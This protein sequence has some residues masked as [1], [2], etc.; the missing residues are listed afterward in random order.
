MIRGERTGVMHMTDT[1]EPGGAERVAVNIVNLLPRESYKPY[2]CTTRRDG[3]LDELVK[4]DV[5]RLRLRRRNRID[6]RALGELASYLRQENIEIVHAH[7][8][9]LFVA[10]AVSV[11][12]PYPVVIWH[13]H[14]GRYALKERSVLLYRLA[15]RR[16]GGVIAVNHPLTVWAEKRLLIPPARVWYIPNFVVPSTAD[17]N[18]NIELPGVAGKRIVCVANLR[19]QKDHATLIQAMRRVVET[20]PAA[21]LLLVG[22]TNDAKCVGELRQLIDDSNLH[23]NVTLLGQRR[24]VADVLARCDIGVLSSLSEGLPLA[25]I[26]YGIA[27]LATVATAIGQ[28]AE[29]LDEGRSGLLVP[30]GHAEALATA[31]LDLLASPSRRADL[32]ERFKRR[33]SELYSP[34]AVIKQLCAVYEQFAARERRAA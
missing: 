21:H 27:G 14:Y 6:V 12:P 18:A 22:S 15:T 34:D 23:R 17:V 30:S 31:L 5:N 13:D 7:G 25:L 10:S 3:A 8:T 20:E 4:Q 19:P 32:G 24:D 1:L 28:C 26:E 2:L 11:L 9:A 16:I 33:A 29:V